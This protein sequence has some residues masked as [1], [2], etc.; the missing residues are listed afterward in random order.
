VPQIF[1]RAIEGYLCQAIG[2]ISAQ[3]RLG[4][5]SFIHRVGASLSRHIHYHVASSTAWT[6]PR[7]TD[8]VSAK[9]CTSNLRRG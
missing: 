9:P 1:L 3:A 8:S 5:V 6:R 4:A 2:T 7:M